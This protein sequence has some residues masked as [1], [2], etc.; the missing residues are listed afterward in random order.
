MDVGF[1]EIGGLIGSNVGFNI[2]P[3]PYLAQFAIGSNPGMTFLAIA[4][5][6][7]GAGLFFLRNFRPNLVRETDVFFAAIGLVCGGILFFQGWR[8]DPILQFAQML[9]A[10]SAVWFAYEAIRMRGITN[11][12]AKRQTPVVDR[13]RSVSRVY[14]A[15]L[16]DDDMPPFEEQRYNRRSIRGRE[17]YAD[18]DYARDYSREN[19]EAEYQDDYRRPPRREGQRLELEGSDRPRRPRSSARPLP[20]ERDWDNNNG[21]DP[22]RSEFDA[23]P[24]S[25]YGNSYGGYEER[26]EPRS[27]RRSRR[28]S[29]EPDSY[30]DNN[31]VD[32][33]PIDYSDS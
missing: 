23:P 20:P 27:K 24:R 21:E 4:L 15:E 6:A 9:S 17:D 30:S 25:D 19:A 13:E 11:E 5:V 18:R 32:Y 1:Q 7:A 2:L 3:V 26:D 31:Y 12:Q 22:F 10:G 16:D 29:S 33:Q 8:L 28:R 14:R